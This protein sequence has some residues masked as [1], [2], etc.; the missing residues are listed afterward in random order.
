MAATAN[1][2]HRP[3]ET[4]ETNFEIP[5][6]GSCSSCHHFHINL[7]FTVTL[8]SMVHTRLYCEKCRHPMFGLGRA[9]TQNT[10]ASVE[11]GSTFIPRVCADRLGQQQPAALQVETAPDVSRHGLLTTIRERRS[12]AP[13]RSTS[14][15]RSPIRAFSTA[16]LAGEE[17]GGSNERT[18]QVESHAL[19]KS[20]AQERL[21]KRGSRPQTATLRRLRIIGRR[22]RRRFCDRLPRIRFQITY[23]HGTSVISPSA[24]T[25]EVSSGQ[26]RPDN[27]E[28]LVNGTGDTED[29]HAFLR[30][31]R[32]ELTLA[33]EREFGTC[34]RCECSHGSCVVHV[35]RTET[36]DNIFV[37]RYLFSHST[38]ESSNS[39]PSQNETPGHDFLHI[40]RVF[41]T[42]Q[43]SSSADESGSNAESLPRRIRLGQGLA[44]WRNRS[45]VSLRARRPLVGR[46][47]SMPVGIRTP[48][49]AGARTGSPINGFTLASGQPEVEAAEASASLD[50][51]SMPGRTNRTDSSRDP[52]ASSHESSTSLNNHVNPQ[53][54][55]QQ[56]GSVN[57]PSHTLMSDIDEIAPTPYSSV[58]SNGS[59]DEVRGP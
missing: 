41:D 32:R 50:D 54:E 57:P 39:Q 3:L 59:R 37:P 11:S 53:Q 12:P 14:N 27:A 8:D 36:P 52:E 1:T 2:S 20:T 46:A 43:R 34:T 31:R 42:P 25:T 10:L 47:S 30:A 23:A 56:V 44:L 51:G 9:S 6:H 29:R 45:S 18:E 55:E 5:F 40:G 38:T 15:V 33:R 35:D 58:H 26:E 21:D 49:L 16:S 24:S 28:E 7:P 17:A 22:F 13:S 4:S 48:Y 19:P